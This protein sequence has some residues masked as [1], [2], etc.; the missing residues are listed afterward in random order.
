MLFTVNDSRYYHCSAIAHVQPTL[1]LIHTCYFI[2][3]KTLEIQS[4]GDSSLNPQTLMSVHEIG[5]TATVM[6]HV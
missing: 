1:P 6:L 4:E 5:M 3:W 2:V